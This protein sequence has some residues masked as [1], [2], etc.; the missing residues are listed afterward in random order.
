MSDSTTVE[1]EAPAPL[2]YQS[3]AV[4]QEVAR[5]RLARIATILALVAIFAIALV[6][7]FSWIGRLSL[8]YDEAW[9]LTL[10]TGRGSPHGDLEAG[11][12]YS[13]LPKFT[14]LEDAPPWW[15]IPGTLQRVTHPPLYSIALRG[16]RALIGDGDIAARAFSAILSALAVLLLYDAVRTLHE[17]RAAGLWAALIMALAGPQIELAQEIRP[18][19]QLVLLSCGALAAIVRVEKLGPSKLRLLAL[20]V[21]VL[22]MMLTQYFAIG[23]CLAL[24]AYAVL[25]LRGAARRQVLATFT[26]AAVVFLLAWGRLLWNQRGEFAN[27]AEGWLQEDPSGHVLRTLERLAAL[28]LRLLYEPQAA[29]Y[30]AAYGAVVLLIAPIVLTLSRKRPEL[31][32]WTLWM[33]GTAGFLALIDLVNTTRHLY[34]VRYIMFAGPAMYA[35]IPVLLPRGWTLLRNTMSFA[36]AAACA[37]ALGA[38]YSTARPDARPLGKFLDAEVA[39]G[40]IIVFNRSSDAFWYGRVLFLQATHYSRH[41]ERPVMILEHSPTPQQSQALSQ[42][43]GVWLVTGT[44]TLQP[45]DLFDGAHSVRQSLF[46]YVCGVDHVVPATQPTSPAP[47]DAR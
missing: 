6:T 18:Y 16:W 10:S 13:G 5:A 20:G 31:L 39:P 1:S 14:S 9:N 12:V 25:R 21:G 26:I 34:F 37:L 36:A 17:S 38:V 46:P 32:L 11:R 45:S 33:L 4:R 22:G 27:A 3:P 23:P 8:H 47:P 43:P 15:R 41:P 2:E 7:R 35:I 30:P 28:P 19:A 40:E 44:D 42:A 24:G 29:T